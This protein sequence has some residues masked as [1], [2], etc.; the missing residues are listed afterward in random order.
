[1]NDDGTTV[2]GSY[3]IDEIVREGG[4]YWPP[5]WR[6]KSTFNAPQLVALVSAGARVERGQLVERGEVTA[7]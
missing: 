2:N 5:R 1:M 6:P 3:L 4:G 7:A